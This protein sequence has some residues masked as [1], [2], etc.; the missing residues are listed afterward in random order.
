MFFRYMAPELMVDTSSHDLLPKADIFSLGA[1]LFEAASL[2]EL[3]KNSDDGELYLQIREG[4]T[5]KL[6]QYSSDFNS[7]LQVRFLSS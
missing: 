2:T 1:T 4:E 6:T 7:M 5:P 3:P